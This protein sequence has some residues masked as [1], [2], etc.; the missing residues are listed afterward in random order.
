[1]KSYIKNTVKFC[2]FL[3]VS[4]F[5]F[6]LVYRDQNWEELLVI[7]KEDVDYT[8]V[9][10]ACVM[11][12]LSH[13]VRAVRWQLLA[14]S[15][16]YRLRFWNSFMGVM[17][18]YFANLAIPRMGEFTRCGVVS[19]YEKVPFSNLLGMVVTERVIDM[20]ILLALTFLMVVTQFKQVGIFL[21]NNPDIRDNLMDLLHSG[22]LLL[23]LGGLVVLAVVLWK[24]L[25][26]DRLQGRIRGFLHGM[27]E[28]LLSVKQVP[29]KGL[30]IFYSLFIWLMY[31]LMFYVCFFC[32]EFTSQLNILVALTCFVLSSYG[33]VAPV[34]GGIGAWHF[35][36]IA[37]LM[38]YLPHTPEIEGM[39][40][41]FALLTHSSMTLLY[42]IVGII[43][44]IAMPLYNHEFTRKNQK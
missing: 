38:I 1:M 36:V 11:G 43:C 27:K 16:G 7:L 28:G 30:F 17:I 34:Q 44:V 13:I 23:V 25:L 29:H 5:L 31:F 10:V 3:V 26:K 19:K 8:W 32:F 20:M 9:G 6:W 4:V 24:Y 35:M 21:D 42:I 39:S 41:I 22:W 12:I 40:K 14:V 2:L 37:S 33:M 15:M 18:G